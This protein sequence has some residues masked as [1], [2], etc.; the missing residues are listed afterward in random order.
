MCK[1]RYMPVRH[2]LR[3]REDCLG[4]G[5]IYDLFWSLIL[6]RIPLPNRTKCRKNPTGKRLLY[7]NKEHS[8]LDIGCCLQAHLRWLK[9]IK[10]SSPNG[11][12]G[13]LV[14]L[15]TYH[16]WEASWQFSILFISM[17][18]DESQR[19]SDARSEAKPQASWKLDKRHSS[20]LPWHATGK[21]PYKPLKK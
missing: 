6:W 14:I 20:N 1:S 5:L 19:K 15:Q 4:L 10:V 2:H 13:V 11:L 3:A 21:S 7:A 18:I 8:N 16:W 17:I 12:L 9:V